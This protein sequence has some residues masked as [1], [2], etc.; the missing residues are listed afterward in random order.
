MGS[1]TR[2][3]ILSEASR[4]FHEQGYAATS[5]AEILSAADV[6]SGSL[7]HFFGSKTELLE[8]VL[9]RYLELLAPELLDPVESDT[10]DGVGRVFALLTQ[11]RPA[12]VASHCRLGCP[13]GALA[14]EVADISPHIR[15]LI[16]RYFCEWVARVRGWLGSAGE[17][18]PAQADPGDLARLVLAVMQ[19]AAVQA[20][21]AATI[22]P[23]D[24][25]VGALRAYFEL[26]RTGTAVVAPPFEAIP[27][28]EAVEEPEAEEEPGWRSW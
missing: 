22:E 9:D 28:Q 11:Y 26:L 24:A 17:E 5:I 8:A 6:R 12:L 3:L 23:F 13:V 1:E 2:D 7:Y 16:D 18:L 10:S 14:L 25:A 20:R 4:L 15:S 21:A 27:P 19:G